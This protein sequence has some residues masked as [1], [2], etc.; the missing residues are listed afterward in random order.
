VKK[1]IQTHTYKYIQT[2]IHTKE[3]NWFQSMTNLEHAKELL[4]NQPSNHFYFICFD[5]S[6]TLYVGNLYVRTQNGDSLYVKR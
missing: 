6:S 4:T 5:V 3:K 2:H 1:Y